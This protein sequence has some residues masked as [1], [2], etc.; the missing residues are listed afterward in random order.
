MYNQNE[1]ASVYVRVRVRVSVAF[2]FEAASETNYKACV[3]T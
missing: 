2:F 1:Y 3:Y